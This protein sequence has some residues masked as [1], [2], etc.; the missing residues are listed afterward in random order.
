[1]DERKATI[2]WSKGQL[3]ISFAGD[4]EED[5]W[6]TV[7]KA[8]SEAELA[9][10]DIVTVVLD[11][12]ETAQI[13]VEG[14]G[15]KAMNNYIRMK[16]SCY[17][18]KK[19]RRI[20]PET[21][22]HMFYDIIPNNMGPRTLDVGA[23]FGQTGGTNAGADMVEGAYVLKNPMP[24]HMY[25]V[26]FYSLIKGGYKDFTDEVYDEDEEIERLERM[27][28]EPEMEC[29]DED[30][31]VLKINEFLEKESRATLSE[32]MNVDFLSNKPPFN[33]RQ[34][35]SAWKEWNKFKY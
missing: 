12:T 18:V 27:F 21:G 2:G 17:K 6:K 29:S 15:L 10:H 16:R 26:K 32:Q 1:M 3:D 20:D 34:V 30:D 4:H 14:N 7:G 24:S 22:A 13:S 5:L 25:W 11:N 33:R 28:E 19:L 9:E 35:T 31:T 8:L 23:R